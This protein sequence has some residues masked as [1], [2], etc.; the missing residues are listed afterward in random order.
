MSWRC[1]VDVSLRTVEI[2]RKI[3]NLARKFASAHGRCR[4]PWEKTCRHNKLKIDPAT[5]DFSGF[6][7]MVSPVPSPRTVRPLPPLRE[8]KAD[9]LTGGPNLARRRCLHLFPHSGTVADPHQ[10]RFAHRPG[11]RH[12]LRE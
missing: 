11:I 12:D 2:R 9:I 7:P 4:S 8:V 10:L 6:S 3:E 1:P 5:L